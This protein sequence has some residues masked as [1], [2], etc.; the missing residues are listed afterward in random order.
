MFQLF[1][2]ELVIVGALTGL[3]W[4]LRRYPAAVSLI[5]LLAFVWSVFLYSLA[6]ARDG[7]G[8]PG[9]LLGFAIVVS[10]FFALPLGLV[11]ML[12]VGN[13]RRNSGDDRLRGESRAERH[14]TGRWS[15]TRPIVLA[16]VAAAVGSVVV[17]SLGER[18]STDGFAPRFSTTLFVLF[19]IGALLVS[20]FR[21]RGNRS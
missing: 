9:Q 8:S 16:V 3:A 12:A 20:A 7:S 5:P 2:I 10:L 14:E 13:W 18:D 19:L 15:R 1:L 17:S 4:R 21:R 6:F 11:G